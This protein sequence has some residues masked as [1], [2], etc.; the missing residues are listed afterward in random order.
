MAP[1]THAWVTGRAQPPLLAAA[2]PRGTTVSGCLHRRHALMGVEFC[3][4]A[5]RLLV[6]IM[7][8]PFFVQRKS[9]GD[10]LARQRR[11]FL[12]MPALQL[13]ALGILGDF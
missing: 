10:L 11:G 8:L 5:L 9:L 4:D 2:W 6:E 7:G 1:R 13:L 3:G 12:S